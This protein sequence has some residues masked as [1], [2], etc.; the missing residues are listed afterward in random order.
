MQNKNKSKN[1]IQSALSIER[2]DKV[3]RLEAFVDAAFAFSVT[4]LVISG[5]H[6]PSSV[7]LLKEAIKQIPAYAASFAIIMQ[8]WMNHADWSRRF[9]LEDS[10][11][12]RLSLL[13]VFVL[14]IFVYPLKMVF[15]SFFALISGGYL[16][17]QFSI[18][19]WSEVPI[20][21]QTFAVGFGG[22]ALITCLLFWR[23]ATLGPLLGF[24]SSEVDY[25][26]HK[27][28]MWAMVVLCS[29]VSFALAVYIPAT[30]KSG[31]WIGMP[32]FIFFGLNI[33][34]II[35]RRRYKKKISA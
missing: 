17:A 18:N 14:L 8:F 10:I 3:T 29:I 15:G 34:Q 24:S 12:E 20:L 21:F 25:A 28:L 22:M 11:S 4:L 32:G 2:G 6:M 9:G 30:P 13:L 35:L 7:A 23:A 1:N 33:L 5:D 26:K 27:R 16:P 19:E 31:V